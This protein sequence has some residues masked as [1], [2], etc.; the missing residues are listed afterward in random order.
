L[1]RQVRV[2]ELEP[3]EEGEVRQGDLLLWMEGREP[4]VRVR[5]IEV[6]QLYSYQDDQCYS[7]V[8]KTSKSKDYQG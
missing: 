5:V 4:P 2:N 1:L 3:L 8:D 6:S 7:A